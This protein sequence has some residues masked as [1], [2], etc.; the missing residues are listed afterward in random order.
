MPMLPLAPPL[1]STIN[2][3]PS[4]LVIPSATRR[5]TISVVPPGAEGTSSVTGRL[6]YSSAAI[7][8]CGAEPRPATEANNARAVDNRRR[9][10]TFILVLSS[11]GFYCHVQSFEQ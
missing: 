11:L 6:G 2:W 10:D 7:A 3:R 1:L 5:A 8:I 9:R 4:S